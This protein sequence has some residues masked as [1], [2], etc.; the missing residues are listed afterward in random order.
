M[1]VL[2]TTGHAAAIYQVSPDEIQWQLEV[3][4]AEP[5]LELNGRRYYNRA[6]ISMAIS[7]L[8]NF[9]NRRG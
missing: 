6:D 2:Q 4:Q 3:I 9:S 5:V 1:Q 8:N 7:Q